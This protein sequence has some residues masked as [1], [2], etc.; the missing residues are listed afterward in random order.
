MSCIFSIFAWLLVPLAFVPATLPIQG[1]GGVHDDGKFCSADAIQSANVVID[2]IRLGSG[3]TVLVET[4]PEI[5]PELNDQLK[6]KGKSRFW[7]EW[8]AA[9]ATERR[10]SGVYVLICR[11]PSH[12]QVA[13]GNVT[14]QTL[15]PL[16]DRD[17]LVRMLLR[18]FGQKQFDQGLLD[19]VQYVQERM[20]A[21]DSLHPG[22]GPV[23]ALG[24]SL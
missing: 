18:Q 4:I 7:E 6:Q 1:A 11:S 21:H 20:K 19:A 12:L 17:E 23:A 8:T 14:Q 22:T 5:P 24:D 3:R 15:F 9:R 16:A 10:I 13:V 2:Q